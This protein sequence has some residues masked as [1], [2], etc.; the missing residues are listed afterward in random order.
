MKNLSKIPYL[1]QFLSIFKRQKLVSH[2]QKKENF[3]SLSN[4]SPNFVG[5]NLTHLLKNCLILK[6]YTLLKGCAFLIWASW[7]VEKQTQGNSS[8][9]RGLVRVFTRR[10]PNLLDSCFGVNCGAPSLKKPCFCNTY[11]PYIWYN[12]YL[13][14]G[15]PKLIIQ[16]WSIFLV[17]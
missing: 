11:L 1:Y 16:F 13:K 7:L 4:Y 5:E 10:V 3:Y 9:L 12:S 15:L 14:Y 17:E 8:V 6:K 2:L